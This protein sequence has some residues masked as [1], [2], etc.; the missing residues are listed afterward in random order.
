[1]KFSGPRTRWPIK[2]RDLQK[3]VHKKN[4]KNLS[5]NLFS[6]P[7]NFV[8]YFLQKV[9]S[10][11]LQV[12]FWMPSQEFDLVH[13]MM[14]GMESVHVAFYTNGEVRGMEKQM[15]DVDI[16]LFNWLEGC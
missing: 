14:S 4:K 9:L 11:R 8:F 6:F 10:L 13:M 2:L 5:H 7:L 16:L 3:Q 1:M 15:I 12:P